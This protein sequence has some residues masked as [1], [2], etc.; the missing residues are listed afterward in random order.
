MNNWEILTLQRVLVIIIFHLN[1]TRTTHCQFLFADSMC[2]VL[3][4]L[5]ISRVDVIF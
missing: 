3:M 2:C 5:Q 1:R 4:N